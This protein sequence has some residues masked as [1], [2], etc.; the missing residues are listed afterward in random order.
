MRR[1]NT[2]VRAITGMTLVTLVTTGIGYLCIRG[3]AK[4][5]AEKFKNIYTDGITDYLYKKLER[6]EITEEEYDQAVD[7]VA[8]QMVLDEK[9]LQALGYKEAVDGAIKKVK[10]KNKLNNKPM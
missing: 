2:N 3:T 7:I 5:E 9:N 1:R 10:T 6:K 8:R 4:T